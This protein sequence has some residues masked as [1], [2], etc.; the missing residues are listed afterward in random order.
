MRAMRWSIALL[1]LFAS[2][3]LADEVS[4]WQLLEL[5]ET[6]VDVA[7]IVAL[8][9][10]ECVD[11]ELDADTLLELAPRLDKPILQ[12]I[13]DC[14]AGGEVAAAESVVIA[15]DAS[16]SG[17]DPGVCRCTDSSSGVIS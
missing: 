2:T 17:S 12:A 8:V 1:L 9:E 15:G 4:R 3:A 5:K 14:R 11:F 7:L 13:F 10:A 6:G 16:A